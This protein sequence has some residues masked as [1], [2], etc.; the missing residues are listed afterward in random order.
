MNTIPLQD[1]A[2]PDIPHARLMPGEVALVGAGP[3]DPGLLT[4]RAWRC[5]QQADAIVHDR[6]VSAELMAMLPERARRYD[7]GKTP[8]NHSMT[9]DTINALLCDLARQGLRV[10]RLKGGDPL[11]FGRGGE[12]LDVLLNHGISC[13][14]VPG[15]TAASACTTYA[16]IPLTHRGVAQSCHFIT[17][18]LQND[19]RLDLPWDALTAPGQTLVFYMGLGAAAS[20][21]RHLIAAGMDRNT[22]AALIHQGSTPRQRVLRTTLAAL[23]AAAQRGAF[24]PPTL[25]VIGAVVELFANRELHYPACF[26]HP[27]LEATC[28]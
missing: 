17:G 27:H 18:H 24:K 11:I 7:T 20:I 23:P 8:G 25:I 26:A 12:E 19:G 3:G 4:L 5:I 13:R 15:I 9:Q 21:S 28:A 14:I 22:P 16:G 2:L 1:M 10:V 6:L